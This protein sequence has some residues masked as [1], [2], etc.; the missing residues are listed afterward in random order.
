MMPAH[1][2]L[3]HTHKSAVEWW[4]L[5]DLQSTSSTASGHEPVLC[6]AFWSKHDHDHEITTPGPKEL[7]CESSLFPSPCQIFPISSTMLTRRQ[8]R[9]SDKPVPRHGLLGLHC[10]VLS[11]VKP[12]AYRVHWYMLIYRAEVFISQKQP[13]QEPLLPLSIPSPLQ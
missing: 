1:V 4:K 5:G 8:I 13:S 9:S 7:R 2:G 3:L 12:V 10:W 6:S 11:R